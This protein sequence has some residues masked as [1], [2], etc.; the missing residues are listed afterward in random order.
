MQGETPMKKKSKRRS[1]ANTKRVS[2]AV[3]TVRC[4][5][6]YFPAKSLL[7][8]VRRALEVETEK[9]ERDTK[10]LVAFQRWLEK[11]VPAGRYVK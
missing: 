11:L 6:F 8:W 4:R 2:V 10:R 5:E 1:T 3:P 9:P 7:K